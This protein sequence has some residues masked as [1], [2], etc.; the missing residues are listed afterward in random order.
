[1]APIVLARL[2]RQYY[3]ESN[4]NMGPLLAVAAQRLSAANLIAIAAAFGQANVDS[5]V[6]S[7]APAST[8]AAYAGATRMAVIDRSQARMV[9]AG[10]SGV[11]A[12][13][14]LDMTIYEVFLDYLTAGTDT[15]V[16]AA[17]AQTSSYAAGWLGAAATFGYSVLLTANGSFNLVSNPNHPVLP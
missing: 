14:N 5:A 15:S 16:A 12:S 11:T 7:Y 1:M 2:S 10:I 13:P 6:A 8:I 4:G 3:I 17:L 9:V